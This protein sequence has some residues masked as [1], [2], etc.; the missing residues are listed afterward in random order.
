MGG[1]AAGPTL[2]YR[3]TSATARHP[4]DSPPPDFKEL[5]YHPSACDSEVHYEA[6]EYEGVDQ[7]LDALDFGGFT[8]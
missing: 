3:A 5:G 6:L 2:G 1:A 7:D 8:F 4:G